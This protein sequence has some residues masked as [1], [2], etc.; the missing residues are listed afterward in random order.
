M[1]GVVN[2]I[3]KRNGEPKVTIGGTVGN[4]HDG[5]HFGVQG[6]CFNFFYDKDYYNEFNEANRIFKNLLMHGRMGKDIKIV[7]WI[8]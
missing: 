3:T 8:S 4:Y 2:I 5:F 7:L 1:G 6:E